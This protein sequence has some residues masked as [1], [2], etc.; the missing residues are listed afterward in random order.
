MVMCGWWDRRRKVDYGR[1]VLVTV[2]RLACFHR[3][4]L[5][6]ESQWEDAPVKINFQGPVI[7]LHN[8]QM[9]TQGNIFGHLSGTFNLL[10]HIERKYWM[11]HLAVVPGS[12]AAELKWNCRQRSWY[13]LIWQLKTN[14]WTYADGERQMFRA[15]IL[16]I[17]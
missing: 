7:S 14:L 6:S 13:F 10:L 4:R 3:P 16:F 1:V 11:E 9:V 12:D 17:L 8:P 15:G 2:H 5:C